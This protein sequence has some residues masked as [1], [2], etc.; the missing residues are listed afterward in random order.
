MRIVPKSYS[1]ELAL[2]SHPNHAPALWSWG[3]SRILA[4]FNDYS[5]PANFAKVDTALGTRR[6]S[7]SYLVTI[8]QREWIMHLQLIQLSILLEM[9][10]EYSFT[11]MWVDGEMQRILQN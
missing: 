9:T 4:E 8:P 7:I 10:L 1:Y 3:T 2:E 6:N 5:R 11:F